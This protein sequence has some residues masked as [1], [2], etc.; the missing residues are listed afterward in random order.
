MVFC[1]LLHDWYVAQIPEAGCLVFMIRHKV[2][3]QNRKVI[4]RFNP[5]E[6]VE[7]NQDSK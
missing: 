2:T 5:R 1:G 6:K 4:K 3:G 7:L